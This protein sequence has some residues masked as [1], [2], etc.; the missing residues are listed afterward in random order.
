M[1]IDKCASIECVIDPRSQIIVM[2]EDVCH[3]MGVLYDLTVTLHMQSVNG[4]VNKSLGLDR[5]SVV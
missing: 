2:S 3:D 1:D 5:K 4:D